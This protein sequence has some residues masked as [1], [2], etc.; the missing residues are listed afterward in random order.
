MSTE[1]LQRITKAAIDAGSAQFQG[2][3]YAV[4][5]VVREIGGGQLNVGSNTMGGKASMIRVLKEAA[6][7]LA[8]HSDLII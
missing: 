3:D 2:R 4:V 8:G 7:A 1:D 5:V 6:E